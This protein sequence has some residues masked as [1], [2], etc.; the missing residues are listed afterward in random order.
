MTLQ[1]NIK[2]ENSNIFLTKKYKRMSEVKKSFNFEKSLTKLEQIV[3]DLESSE[4]GLDKSLKSYEDGV[5]L[6]NECQ[7]YLEAAQKKV[8][9]LTESLDSKN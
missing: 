9:T 2:L 8:T 6:Y 5:K 3:Q 1:I 7:K 4:V